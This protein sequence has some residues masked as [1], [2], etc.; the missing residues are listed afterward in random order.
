M[1]YADAALASRRL[2]SLLRVP[3]ID[4]SGKFTPSQALMVDRRLVGFWTEHSER[5]SLPTWADALGGFSREWTDALGRWSGNGSAGYMRTHRRRVRTIQATV[6]SR[7]QALS[8]AEDLFDEAELVNKGASFLQ[9]RWGL[10]KDQAAELLLPLAWVGRP[11]EI[12]TLDHA[13]ED[14]VGEASDQGGDTEV[15]TSEGEDKE[16]DNQVP[17]GWYV[18]SLRG[19]TSKRCLHKVGRCYRV[20]G[21]DYKRYEVLGA[22]IPENAAVDHYCRKCWST[23]LPTAH[24]SRSSSPSTSSSCSSSSSGAPE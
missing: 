14:S 13:P 5:S 11:V 12:P 23:G 16:K 20:P 17:T 2:L 1:K 21:L 6:A 10:S 4:D 15:A 8:K 3:I 18:V 24:G 19:R 22:T 9:V 7:M